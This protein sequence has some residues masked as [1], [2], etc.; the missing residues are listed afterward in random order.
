MLAGGGSESGFTN[1]TGSEARF[2]Y[3]GHI[4]IDASGNIYVADSENHA[5]RKI[6]PAGVVTTIA[7]GTEGSADGTGTAASFNGPMGIAIGPDGHLYIG[8]WGNHTIR[9]ITLPDGVVTTIAGIAGTSG[10][11]N[12]SGASATFYRPIGLAFDASG[13]L[14]VADHS[15]HQIRKITFTITGVADAA[16]DKEYNLTAR[17]GEIAISSPGKINVQVYSLT[18]AAIYSSTLSAGSHTIPMKQGVYMVKVNGEVEKVV[19]R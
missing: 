3:P 2:N 8:E 6:T 10:K 17:K 1:G 13:N 19:V 11:A 5:I 12:G 15:N 7:G 14:Y 4:A 16:A 18:G 9:K